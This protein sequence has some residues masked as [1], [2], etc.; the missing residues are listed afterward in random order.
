[1][2]KFEN[3]HSNKKNP[4]KMIQNSYFSCIKLVPKYYYYVTDDTS[5]LVY[6]IIGDLIIFYFI[7]VIQFKIENI[8]ITARL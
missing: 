4:I 3:N 1:L 7:I 2:C 8:L 6:P 5:I